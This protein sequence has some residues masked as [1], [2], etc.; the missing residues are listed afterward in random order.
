MTQLKIHEFQRLG[1]ASYVDSKAIPMGRKFAGLEHA[2]QRFENT[3][4]DPHYAKFINQTQV[5]GI[6][7]DHDYGT[8]NGI[9]TQALMA[10]D[11]YQWQEINTLSIKTK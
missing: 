6:W 3:K 5:V 2:I 8:G 1:D 7:D 9:S 4:S 10:S 11:P